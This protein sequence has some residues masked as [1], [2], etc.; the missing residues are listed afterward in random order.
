VSYLSVPLW[1]LALAL[2]LIALSLAISRWH[3]LELEKRLL[4]GTARAAVQL[5][6]AG[7]VLSFVFAHDSPFLVFGFVLSMW[8]VAAITAARR[9]E[10]GPPA[11]ELFPYALASVGI[12]AAVVLL[13]VFALVL[14]PTRWYEP[15][16]VIP[17]GGMMLSA[18]MNVVSQVFERVFAQVDGDRALVEQWLALGASPQQAIAAQSRAA[19]RSALIPQLNALITL[20]LVSLPG[21]MTG[22][23]VSGTDPAQAVRYQLVIMYQLVAVA[24]VAGALAV[25][26][27]RRLLF[28]AREQLRVYAIQ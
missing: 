5:F 10:H 27:A 22:Q 7:A 12:G 17:I 26:F 11:R 2:V 1:R 23:I 14:R 20:G 19:L 4:I 8:V 25:F 18:A 24:A 13:P 28:N 3:A 15:R 6:A 21:M 9:T 16:L